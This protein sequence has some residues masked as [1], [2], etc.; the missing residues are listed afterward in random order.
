MASTEVDVRGD[1]T[2]RKSACPSLYAQEAPNPPHEFR[3]IDAI[4]HMRTWYTS[5]AHKIS[6][7][8]G[9][10]TDIATIGSYFD[11]PEYIAARTEAL[12]WKYVAM[13]KHPGNDWVGGPQ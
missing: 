9:N 12:G 10:L 11:D 4:L 8:F 2:I 6:D 1:Y 3:L 5:G 7:A 13:A